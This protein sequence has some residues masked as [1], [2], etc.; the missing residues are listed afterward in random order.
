MGNP[1]SFHVVVN[2][3]SAFQFS[4][5]SKNHM[6]HLKGCGFFFFFFCCGKFSRPFLQLPF[7]RHYLST[8]HCTKKWGEE[9][10]QNTVVHRTEGWS[11]CSLSQHMALTF[12]QLPRLQTLGSFSTPSSNPCIYSISK[13]CWL[14]LR[15]VNFFQSPLYQAIQTIVSSLLDCYNHLITGHPLNIDMY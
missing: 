2:S 7:V 9:D 8:R 4:Y 3:G 14:Y 11:R 10:E 6:K 15:H 1:H 13:L 5:S 12:I